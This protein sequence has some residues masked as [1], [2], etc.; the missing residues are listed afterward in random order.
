MVYD[1]AE[2]VHE[3]CKVFREIVCIIHILG[4]LPYIPEIVSHLPKQISNGFDLLTSVLQYFKKKQL[5]T[6]NN[7]EHTFDKAHS[8]PTFCVL[9]L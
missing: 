4:F 8:F 5:F 7:L 9:S 6:G 3:T 1:V 2:C